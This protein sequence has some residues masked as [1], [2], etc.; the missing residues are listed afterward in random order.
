M[1]NEQL[2]LVSEFHTLFE[3]P[4]LSKEDVIPI[5]RR[6]LRLAL[7]FEELTELAEA[8]GLRK[9]FKDTI[10]EYIDK[11]EGFYVLDEETKE[12]IFVD[13]DTLIL[14]KK[15]VLDATCDLQYILCGTVLENGQQNE[16]DSAFEDVHKS[17]I[18]KLCT[19]VQEALDTKIKYCKDGVIVY[20]KNLPDGYI[21]IYRQEDHKVLKSINYKPVELEKY[22]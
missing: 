17:N 10:K 18:S 22:V 16:F 15:E 8:Y 1:I 2:E 13:I 6:R 14:N 5:D 7:L 3:Q 21:G 4:I 12:K 19:T 11:K 9:S 20:D